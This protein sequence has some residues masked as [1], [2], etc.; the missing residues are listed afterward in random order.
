LAQEGIG[1]GVL[2]SI[3]AVLHLLSTSTTRNHCVYVMD[4]IH[5]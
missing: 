1:E 3:C 4:G 2:R 5:D